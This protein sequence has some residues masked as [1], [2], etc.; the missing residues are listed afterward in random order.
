LGKF[1]AFGSDRNNSDSSNTERV[2]GVNA[3]SI[4]STYPRTRE[5]L[6]QMA[7]DRASSARWNTIT[8]VL[9]YI[10][11]IS[12][13]LLTL[14]G[15][16]VLL[17]VLV[18]VLG[19]VALGLLSWSRGSK[20]EKKFYTQQLHLLNE[21]LSSEP[22]DNLEEVESPLTQREHD[23]LEQAAMGKS[24]K[25]IGNNLGISEVTVRSH[26]A[27]IFTKLNVNDRLSAVVIAL[28]SGWIKF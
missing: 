23:V 28:R 4:D 2:L 20:L 18:A 12:V 8:L 13:I 3:D 15:A 19:L 11:L 21:L 17:I 22:D 24:N 7:I 10:P 25:E 16:D 9:I 14:V 26:F 27:H 5:I 6:H 1:S